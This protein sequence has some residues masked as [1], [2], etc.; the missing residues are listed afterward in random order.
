MSQFQKAL[1][2]LRTENTTEFNKKYA[3]TPP[4]SPSFSAASR[5]KKVPSQFELASLALREGS[6]IHF[7]ETYSFS[8]PKTRR[9]GRRNRK[10]RKSSRKLRRTK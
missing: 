5:M 9:K 4:S 7:N 2:A 1:A 8:S 6:P 10:T 3:V